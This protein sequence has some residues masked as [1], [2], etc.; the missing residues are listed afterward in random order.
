MEHLYIM[1]LHPI[2]INKLLS[3]SPLAAVTQN[4]IIWFGTLMCLYK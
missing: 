2:F 3:P 1:P 4:G